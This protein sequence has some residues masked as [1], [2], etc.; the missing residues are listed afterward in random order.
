MN[1]YHRLATVAITVTAIVATTLAGTTVANAAAPEG[2]AKKDSDAVSGDARITPEVAALAKARGAGIQD[3]LGAY[4]TPQRMKAALPDTEIPAVKA[5]A[6]RAGTQGQTATTTSTGPQG[7]AQRVEGTVSTVLDNTAVQNNNQNVSPEAFNPNFPIGHPTAA[8]NGKVFFT[9]GGSNFV[10]SGTTV[11]TEGKAAVWTAGHCVSGSGQFASNWCFVPNYVNGS[12]PFGV[13]C[14]YQLWTLNGWLFNGDFGFDVGTALMF[15]QFG[16]CIANYLGAQGIAWNFPIGQTV[17]AFGY[18][19]APPFDGQILWA[20]QGS[21][22]DGTSFPIPTP[23]TIFMVNDMTGGS[24]GGP[25]LAFYDGFYGY[26]N[27][28]NDFKYIPGFEAYMFSPYYGDQV[29][30]LYDAIRF[31]T[32]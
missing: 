5:A 22:F 13:W 9:L 30:G 10:C 18:P 3:A 23:G 16:F 31:G 15:S 25:W 2:A 1:I 26:I 19:A 12:A 6:A 8:T 29:A 11:N 21:Q 20:E 24:S 7:S 27:G 4:W 14:A 28:H 32:C 17:F